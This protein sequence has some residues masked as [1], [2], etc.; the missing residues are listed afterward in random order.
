MGLVPPLGFEDLPLQS[1]LFVCRLKKL[2][3]L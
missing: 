1:Q 2:N 3:F